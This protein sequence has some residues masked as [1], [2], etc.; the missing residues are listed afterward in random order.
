M[1]ATSSKAARKLPKRTETPSW[2]GGRTTNPVVTESQRPVGPRPS[3]IKNE[4][5]DRDSRDPQL[6][7]NLSRLG[8]VRVDHHMQ[9]YRLD[10]QVNRMH[11]TRARSE[12]EATPSHAAR[13]RILS[14]TL[15]ELLDERKQATSFKELERIANK[16]DMDIA[17]LES[18]ARFV[19]TPTI[20]EGTTTRTKDTNEEQIITSTAVWAEAPYSQNLNPT[21]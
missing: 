5:I 1:G 2:A 12:I 16:Y 13:N 4:A 3:E 17:K 21:P 11:Q 6:L 18:L 9:S 7:S 10:D 8:P 20:G 19:N 15:S 14:A